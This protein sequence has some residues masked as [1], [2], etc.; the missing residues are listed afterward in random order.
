M[1]S[2]AGDVPAGAMEPILDYRRGDGSSIT[3]GYVYRGSAIPAL[4]G[5][6]IYA[7]YNSDK[8]WTVTWDGSQACDAA[9]IADIFDADGVLSGITSFGEDANGELYV[10]V[11]GGGG[12]VYRVD[13]Q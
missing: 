7:D 10:A 8:I 13:P 2:L 12:G 1:C 6:Y 11:T 5:R 9:E 4:Q 3:G